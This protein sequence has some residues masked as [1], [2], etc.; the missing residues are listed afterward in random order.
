MSKE[1]FL[2][3]YILEFSDGGPR[4]GGLLH[5]GTKEECENTARIIPAI[6]YSGDRPLKACYIRIVP[7]AAP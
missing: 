2:C 5:A 4:E 6:C 7:E 1:L 3:G